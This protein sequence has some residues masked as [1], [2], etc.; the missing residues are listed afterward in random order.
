MWLWDSHRNS[1]CVPH[2][3][4]GVWTQELQ[5][6]DS[7]HAV[8]ACGSISSSHR[9]LCLCLKWLPDCVASW[10]FLSVAHSLLKSGFRV[11]TGSPS[12]QNKKTSGSVLRTE[13]S[14]ERWGSWSRACP[15]SY[16]NPE[17]VQSTGSMFHSV[18]FVCVCVCATHRSNL[19]SGR[20]SC[21]WSLGHT[22]LLPHVFMHASALGKASFL[23]ASTSPI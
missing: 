4:T 6:Y 1:A 17:S 19:L 18:G 7:L 8:S 14:G 20:P 9:R 10:V 12:Q 5:L 15:W 3:H 16:P 23:G 22:K 2:L 21:C 13:S 11:G